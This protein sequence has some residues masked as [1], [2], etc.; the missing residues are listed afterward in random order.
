[1]RLPDFD[2]GEDG[3]YF[4]TI[5]VEGRRCLLGEVVGDS[6]IL[7]P[8]GDAV[9]GVWQ[10]LSGHFECVEL[11]SFVVMPNHF[12]AIVWIA[13]GGESNHEA[14][15][16]AAKSP[17]LGQIVGWF[18]YESTRHI[19]AM[20]GTPG[21]RLWQRGYYDHIVRSEA[22]LYAIAEYI[23]GNPGSWRRDEMNPDL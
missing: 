19:N 4:I 2:Y 15:S 16:G 14:I 9:T 11:G 12:H 1:M 3:A 22:G 8:C 10:A 21:R 20:Q 23:E 6:M 7:S 13:R 18:K 17:T 5:C